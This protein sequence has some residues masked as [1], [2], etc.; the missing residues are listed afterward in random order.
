MNII[1]TIRFWYP[2]NI[3]RVIEQDELT[4]LYIQING[5]ERK[6]RGLLSRQGILDHKFKRYNLNIKI[7]EINKEVWG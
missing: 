5:S 2:E 6:P 1:E 4:T 3:I 7:K